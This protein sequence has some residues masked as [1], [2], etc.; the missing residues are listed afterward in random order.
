VEWS[1][2]GGHNERPFGGVI[3]TDHGEPDSAT[4]EAHYDGGPTA[5][6]YQ[7]VATCLF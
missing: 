4:V 5:A 3:S 1:N 7:A 2:S 6:S